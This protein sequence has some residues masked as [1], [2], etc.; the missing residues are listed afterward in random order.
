MKGFYSG[1]I[2][3]HR[4]KFVEKPCTDSAKINK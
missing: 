4:D 2:F 1:E 3:I